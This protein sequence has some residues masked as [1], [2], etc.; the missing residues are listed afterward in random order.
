LKRI[1]TTALAILRD[2]D[3]CP[4]T[5]FSEGLVSAKL[6]SILEENSIEYFQDEYGNIIAKI[7]GTES[8]HRPIAYVAHMDHPG[9]EIVRSQEGFFVGK[10]LGGVPKA[11][12]NKGADCFSFDMENNR[13]PCSIEPWGEGEE[14][15]VKVVSAKRLTVGTP[16]TFDLQDFSLQ[17]DRIEMR[18]LDDLAGCAST[19]AALI[20]LN[21]EPV[22]TDIFGVFTRAEEVG[23]VGA[24]LVSAEQTIPSN[25]FVVSVETS[26]IIPGVE[27]GMGPVIR[28]GDASYTFDAEAE[29]ILSLAKNVL[30][31]QNSNFQ[32]QRQLMAAGSCEATAFAVN[33]YSTTGIAFPLG[34][35][36]NATTKIPDANGDIGMENISLKDFLNGTDLI[37]TSAS[38]IPTESTSQV[39]ERL[40]QVRHK[41]K[42]RLKKQS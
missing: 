37:F 38:M 41:L 31:T 19:M 26:S 18:A 11:A 10:S 17:G 3:Q 40:E 36:H 15:E 13:Y 7:S 4:A 28:T 20:E 14:G 21:R 2:L 39:K 34:N 27:Q 25:T 12:A 6:R 29:Q 42:N 35:W 24:G 1:H 30:L 22:K 5:A 8:A 33:G 23:L 32:C 16:I 9:Y